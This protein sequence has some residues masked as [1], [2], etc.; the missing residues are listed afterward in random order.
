M[1]IRSVR[2]STKSLRRSQW[3]GGLLAALALWCAPSLRAEDA[4]Y[5]VP[6]AGLGLAE[7]VLHMHAPILRPAEPGFL[8]PAMQPYASLDGEGEV[9]VGDVHFEPWLAGDHPDHPYQDS[10]LAV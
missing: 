10:F 7:G 4:F 2:K 5:R 6:L 8:T 1:N 9:Y 3:F